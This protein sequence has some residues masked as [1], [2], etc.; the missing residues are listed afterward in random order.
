MTSNELLFVENGIK[1]FYTR[2]NKNSIYPGMNV[3][4]L[5]S[6]GVGGLSRIECVQE[7]PVEDLIKFNLLSGRSVT[8]KYSGHLVTRSFNDL[9]PIRCKDLSKGDLI[10]VVANSN[11]NSSYTD[12]YDGFGLTY[13]FGKFIGDLCIRSLIEFE[14]GIFTIETSPS[15]EETCL[16]YN[17]RA[18]HSNE[19]ELK[20]M[21][22]TLAKLFCIIDGAITVPIANI[23]NMNFVAGILSS[24]FSTF[25]NISERNHYIYMSSRSKTFLE[26][27]NMLLTRFDIL[28]QFVRDTIIISN[29]NI[30]RF[31]DSIPLDTNSVLQDRIQKIAMN[32]MFRNEYAYEDVIPGIVAPQL[33]STMNRCD[34]P[35]SYGYQKDI[36]F[37]RIITITLLPP[38][39]STYTIQTTNPFHMIANGVIIHT[40]L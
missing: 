6:R 23:S 17:L 2:S 28:S 9:T 13:S 5:D 4:A 40:P 1:S 35:S 14:E 37:D 18:V 11:Y 15:I 26:F 24:I 33:P 27:I 3:Y 12:T 30:Y 16:Q 20:I 25:G 19:T 32:Y 21:S 34:L 7:N 36:Y 38:S 22:K 39:S 31:L 8:M 10:A 29:R